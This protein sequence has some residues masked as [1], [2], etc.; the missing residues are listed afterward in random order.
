MSRIETIGR[1]GPD[2]S[3][4]VYYVRYVP[5]DQYTQAEAIKIIHQYLD[6]TLG[7]GKAYNIRMVFTGAFCGTFICLC[8]G[9]P[10]L[11]GLIVGTSLCGIGYLLCQEKY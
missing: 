8:G 9:F 4:G 7:K 6:H 1:Y 11:A 10:I 2:G 3:F 5:H